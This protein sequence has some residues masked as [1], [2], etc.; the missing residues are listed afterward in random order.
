MSIPTDP[1]AARLLRPAV[2]G[3]MRRSLRSN[4]ARV[5]WV[6]DW[7]TPPRDRPLIAYAN[8][9]YF[10]DGYLAWLM[11]QRVLNRPGLI[12]MREWDRVPFFRATGAL[13]FPENDPARRATTMRYTVRRLREE[14][15]NVLIYFPEGHLHPPEDDIAP[16]DTTVLT[17]IDRILPEPVW[18]P[19]AMHV[20]W[21]EDSTPTVLMGGGAASMGISG[22]E[23]EI[24]ASVL[25]SVRAASP[26]KGQLILEGNTSMHE[27]WSFSWLRPFFSPP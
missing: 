16:F 20:T 11:L 17:R 8:H 21:W 9:H 5:C 7:P 19:F 24:L 4:F 18:W 22:Q 25:Q 12:W 2:A 14:P 3:L 10:H 23:P 1:L 13:P 15:E 26:G 27:R 6:G